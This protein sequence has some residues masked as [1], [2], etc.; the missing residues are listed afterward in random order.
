[1]QRA[2][3]A[4]QIEPLTHT[5]N[6]VEVGLRIVDRVR[7]HPGWIAA[8]VVGLMAIRPR[9]LSSFLRL[10]SAGLRTWRMLRP[11]LQLLLPG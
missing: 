8:A 2:D 5:M 10:G 11:S 6:S 7:Q 1:M 4:L 3:L 9:R